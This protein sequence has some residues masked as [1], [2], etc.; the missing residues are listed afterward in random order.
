MERIFIVEDDL[1]IRSE[2]SALLTKYGYTCEM[3]DDYEH[4]VSAI[5]AHSPHLVLL[6][7]NLPYF[8]GYH[9]C[10]ELRK[11][12][13]LPLIIV[14]SRDSQLDELMSLNLGA[15]DFIPTPYHP[16]ILLAR[17]ASVLKRSYHTERGNVLEHRGVSLNCAEGSVSCGGK[18][19]ELTKNELRIL[20]LLM[21]HKGQILTRAQI[22]EDLW[23]S[24]EYI[25]DNT[26]TVNINR[27]RRK[28]EEID[29]TDFLLTRRGQGYKV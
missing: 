7:I 25:D 9:I 14:T 15:D 5:L 29:V 11:R 13:D 27:L 2:L 8:D 22:M 4:L 1:K 24:E 28:L 21:E 17:I 18:T 23:Q 16:Q 12:S 10:R 3:T 20:K 26:L 19:V 6:D